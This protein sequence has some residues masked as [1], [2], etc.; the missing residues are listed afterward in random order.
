L[1]R[2]FLLLSAV[3]L[4]V[5]SA[6]APSL[7]K[8]P[9]RV[10]NVIPDDIATDALGSQQ[11]IEIG[12]HRSTPDA[13]MMKSIASIDLGLQGTFSHSRNDIAEGFVSFFDQFGETDP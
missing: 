2:P 13:M 9:G 7:S 11:A 5:C 10:G 3:D 12:L 1:R 4:Y 8:R 6:G